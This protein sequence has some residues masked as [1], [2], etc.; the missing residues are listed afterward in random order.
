MYVISL[1]PSTNAFIQFTFVWSFIVQTNIAEE[2]KASLTK[3]TY[4]VRRKL[5]V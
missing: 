2:M 1:E 4:V 5:L 3:P